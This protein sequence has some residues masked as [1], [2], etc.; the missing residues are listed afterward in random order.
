MRDGSNSTYTHGVLAGKCLY[1]TFDADVWV[2]RVTQGGVT[3][4]VASKDTLGL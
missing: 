1:S 3:G 4:L 2:E